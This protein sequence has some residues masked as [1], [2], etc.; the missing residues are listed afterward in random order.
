MR[1]G[2][3]L[4]IEK[5]FKRNAIITQKFL[6][7]SLKPVWHFLPVSGLSMNILCAG[8]K[9]PAQKG[10]LK[11]SAGDLLPTL[12]FLGGLCNFCN[13]IFFNNNGM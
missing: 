12:K 7:L 2:T 1:N 8:D 9:S 3:K 11:N 4:G 10:F 5:Y 13:Y 6:V